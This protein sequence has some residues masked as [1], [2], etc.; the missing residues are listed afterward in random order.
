MSTSWPKMRRQNELN[1][2]VSSLC[3]IHWLRNG[4]RPII[5]LYRPFVLEHKWNGLSYDI[6]LTCN[7]RHIKCG[8]Q[9]IQKKIHDASQTP[10]RQHIKTMENRTSISKRRELHNIHWR[11]WERFISLEFALQWEENFF[12]QWKRKQ[13]WKELSPFWVSLQNIC[14]VSRRSPSPVLSRSVDHF[15]N[16]Y[17]QIY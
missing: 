12:K 9:I 7:R 5:I 1:W 10:K 2:I 17:I 16:V 3:P 13:K 15:K 6:P 8:F 4:K 11:L 14:I